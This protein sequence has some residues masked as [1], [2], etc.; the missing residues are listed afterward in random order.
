MEVE[1][2]DEISGNFYCKDCVKIDKIGNPNDK[3]LSKIA[4]DI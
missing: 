2:V 3:V 4:L 1:F